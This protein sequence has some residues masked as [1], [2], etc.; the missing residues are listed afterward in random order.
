MIYKIRIILDADNDVV[1]RDIEIE[2]TNSLE[3]LHVAIVNAC[4]LDGKEVA[5][6]YLSNQHWDQ[7]EE[8]T[9]FD[10]GAGTSI[11]VMNKVCIE[12]VLQEKS[13]RMIYVYDFINIWT[14][15]VEL[16]ETKPIEVGQSYPQMVYTYGIMPIEAPKREFEQKHSSASHTA[17]DFDI[18]EGDNTFNVDDS[19]ES[20]N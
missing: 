14:F 10:M 12:E 8:I 18:F 7:N 1:F 16:I 13:D 17:E 5:S 4:E 19:D 15:Y 9:L 2:K 20:W 3:D 11:R 6:F